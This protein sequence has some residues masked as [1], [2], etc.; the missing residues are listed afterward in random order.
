MVVRVPKHKGTGLL[1]IVKALQSARGEAAVPEHLRHYLREQIMASAWYPEADYN[2]LLQVLAT[3]AATDEVPDVWALFGVTGAQ[4]DLAGEQGLV[5]EVNRLENVGVYRRFVG[6]E[7]TSVAT[8]FRRM[9]T[10]WSAYHDTGRIEN[11]VSATDDC[12][13]YM[14]VFDFKVPVRGIAELTTAYTCEYARL[15]GINM[16]GRVTRTTAEGA[17]YNEWEYIVERSPEAVLS[18]AELRHGA[19]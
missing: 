10:L 12:T 18:I 8:M 16:R 9:V 17:A 19:R 15:V 2:V 11:E 7:T 6:S 3:L 13:V 4:R 1:P 5:R 14:R